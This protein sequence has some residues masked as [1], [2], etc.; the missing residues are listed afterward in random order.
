MYFCAASKRP[1]TFYVFYKRKKQEKNGITNFA[2][3]KKFKKKEDLTWVFR[4]KFSHARIIVIT[5]IS[6]K[7][8]HTKKF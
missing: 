5:I 7:K 6:L 8:C 1:Q 4:R 2:H 3:L